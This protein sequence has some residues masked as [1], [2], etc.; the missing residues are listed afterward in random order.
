MSATDYLPYPM[1]WDG[2]VQSIKQKVSGTFL[3]ATHD[4]SS[5]RFALDEGR[6]THCSYSRLHGEAALEAFTQIEAGRYSL[7]QILYPFRAVASIAHDRAVTIL[8]IPTPDLVLPANKTLLDVA[9]LP[10]LVSD[11]ELSVAAA[12]VK[13]SR[14]VSGS[15]FTPAELEKLFGKFYFE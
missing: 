11:V 15:Q 8:G 2:L 7:N 12:P 9:T 3:I 1:L 13:T 5:C 14:V 10:Q 6:L 4:N